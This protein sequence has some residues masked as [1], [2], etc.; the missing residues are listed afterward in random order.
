[1][2][3]AAGTAEQQQ[4]QYYHWLGCGMP[5]NK[6]Q[7]LRFIYPD[8]DLPL[9]LTMSILVWHT[10]YWIAHLQFGNHEAPLIACRCSSKSWQ[11]QKLA[12]AKPPNLLLAHSYAQRSIQ[13]YSHVRA[14]APPAPPQP[15]ANPITYMLPPCHTTPPCHTRSKHI[16]LLAALT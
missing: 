8:P 10:H 4:N 14:R 3:E 7:A 5:T 16:Q 9:T 2:G 6:P 15:A 1:M 12:L 11:V 13:R